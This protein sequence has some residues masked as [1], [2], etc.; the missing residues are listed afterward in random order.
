MSWQ[1]TATDDETEPETATEDETSDL[2][3]RVRETLER[4]RAALAHA[5]EV[6]PDPSKPTPE[7][8]EAAK[9]SDAACAGAQPPSYEPDAEAPYRAFDHVM[10][11]GGSRESA[12]AA[13]VRTRMTEKEP[14]RKR[15]G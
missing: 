3:E 7:E 2:A 13:A 9:L 5:A 1:E 14:R 10:D 4:S 11:A 8:I 15:D 6:F 12:I